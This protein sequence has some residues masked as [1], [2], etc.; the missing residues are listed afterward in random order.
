MTH[1]HIGRAVRLMNMAKN[2][3]PTVAV[4]ETLL[5]D[6]GRVDAFVELLQRPGAA[7]QIAGY[8]A[9]LQALGALPELQALALNDAAFMKLV[10]SIPSAMTGFISSQSALTAIAENAA[11]RAAFIASTALAKASVPNMTSNTAP[12]GVAS[13]SSEFAHS[14]WY[15]AF[16]AFD[17]VPSDS[18]Y[19]GGASGATTNQWLQ[20]SFPSGAFI[21]TVDISNSVIGNAIK[22][23]RIEHSDNGVNFVTAKSVAVNPVGDTVIPI[24]APGFHKHWRVF[25]ESTVGGTNP[26]IKALNFRGFLQP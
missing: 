11:V 15:L 3:T 24:A 26:G 8:P 5:T 1:P 7:G 22:D 9:L 17:G 6:Q 16:R 4:L 14:D 2:G 25:V 19:W 13:A 10:A 20:Y 18:Q 21:H 12:S 23:I